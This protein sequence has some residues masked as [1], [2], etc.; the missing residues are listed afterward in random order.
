MESG[1]LK[2]NVVDSFSLLYD[3]IIPGGLA[4]LT[5]VIVGMLVAVGFRKRQLQDIRDE[6]KRSAKQQLIDKFVDLFLSLK[7]AII[8]NMNDSIEV[9]QFWSESDFK[10]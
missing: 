5:G 4:I 2:V 7:K 3:I 8:T 6:S 1:I 10:Q 9:L